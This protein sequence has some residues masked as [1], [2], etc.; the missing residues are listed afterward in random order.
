MSEENKPIDQ[1]SIDKLYDESAHWHV[2]VGGK[3]IHPKETAGRF[4]NYKYLTWLFWL[5]YFILPYIRVAGEQIVLFDIPNRQ[6]HFFGATVYPQ[7]IW[8]LSFVLILLAMMLFGITAI[9]GRVFCGYWC[10]QTVWTDWFVYIE[11]WIEGTPIQRRK[12]DDAPF[13]I[14][15]LWKRT[16]K[17]SIWVLISLLT[18]VTFAAYFTDAYQLWVD[19]LT[20]QANMAAWVTLL[21]FFFG[22][23]LFAGFMREQVCFWLCPY[24]RIQSVMVDKQTVLPTYDIARGEPRGKLKEKSV[25][26]QG[27]C[28]DC[29]VCVAVCPTGVDIREGFQ[30]G[31]ITCGLCIDACDTIMEKVNK[32]AGLIRYASQNEMQGMAVPPMIKRPRVVAYF[33]LMIISIAAIIYGLATIPPVDLHVLHERQPMYTQMSNGSIQNLYTFKILNKTKEDMQLTILADGIENLQIEGVEQT[34][35]LKPNKMIPFTVKLKARPEAIAAEKVP[36]YFRV[37]SINSDLVDETKESFFAA[38]RR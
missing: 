6:F 37:K 21:S 31:C 23:F 22:T 25:E 28:I 5:S 4:R 10:F 7:D 26:T 13:T 35:S 29:K 8:M 19:Y 33:V 38:P 2:N 36:V 12:L 32:P 24:A 20:L 16:A 14:E 1:L 18:G 15:K 3:K 27:D 34:I 17:Y 30:E 9:A 11:R